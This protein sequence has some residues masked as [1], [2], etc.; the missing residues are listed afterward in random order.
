[1][2][3]QR[4][5]TSENP[6][7]KDVPSVK[8]QVMEIPDEWC[9]Y[10]WLTRATEIA[11]KDFRSGRADAASA[12]AAASLPTRHGRFAPLLF[13]RHLLAAEASVP[14]VPV[15]HLMATCEGLLS[16][17][18]AGTPPR[19]HKMGAA[20]AFQ[21]LYCALIDYLSREAE[22]IET[23]VLAYS[24]IRSCLAFRNPDAAVLSQVFHWLAHA[25]VYA[26]HPGQ[27]VAFDT[28]KADASRFMEFFGAAAPPEAFL[29]HAVDNL[30][31]QVEGV[32]GPDPLY[33]AVK[34]WRQTR[35]TNSM[36]PFIGPWSWAEL[37]PVLDVLYPEGISDCYTS[38]RARTIQY[39]E[40]AVTAAPAGV[41][42]VNEALQEASRQ[43]GFVDPSGV[44]LLVTQAQLSPETASPDTYAWNSTRWP[45]LGHDG[46]LL[47]VRFVGGTTI[48]KTSVLLRYSTGSLLLDFGLA[49]PSLDEW[50]WFDELDSVEAV[51]LSHAHMDHIGGFLPLYGTL[52]RPLPW[53]ALEGNERIIDTVLADAC[54]LSREET[55]IHQFSPR[56]VDHVMCN[57]NTARA[58][59]AVEVLPGVRATAFP[60][61]HVFGACSWLVE[62]DDCRVFFTGDFTH[63]R[64]LACMGLQWPDE[65]VL[66]EVDILITEGT[67]ADSNLVLDDAM[68]CQV[69]LVELT[70]S[71][72]EVAPCVLVPVMSLG[73]AQEVIRSLDG[74]GLRSGLFGMA[75]QI[76]KQ[77][78]LPMGPD[79]FMIEH[80]GSNWGDYVNGLDVLVAS[81]GSLSGGPSRVLFEEF[82]RAMPS[83]PVILTGHQFAGTAGRLL[84][85]EG[86][87]AV[88]FSAHA[89]QSDFAD[90]LLLFPKAR[91]F[92][93]HFPG[94]YMRLQDRYDVTVPFGQYGF[95]WG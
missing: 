73:R 68:T 95:R 71:L 7:S 32:A 74:S 94:D 66:A 5:P 16:K 87:H 64:P 69:K 67:Y 47:S 2:Q 13:Y 72:L 38:L 41:L 54:K 24:Y 11:Y 56:L 26:T 88:R 59:Q 84:E 8:S 92:V 15:L 34:N 50:P 46:R 48:G 44:P 37:R 86:G 22:D 83:R 85:K 21:A 79:T 58:G 43:T 90:T 65:A 20:V 81:S 82:F 31:L 25:A 57:L 78:N 23:L 28:L 35:K 53:F 27:P 52:Q 62:S 17:I 39:A 60:S 80:A 30:Y 9:G 36:E 12:V 63:R 61:G 93:I 14:E 70:R 6:A 75:S 91:K 89:S 4:D 40:A 77:I 10:P 33:E 18:A 19:P 29:R 51:L 55:A 42:P 49:N 76:T 1:M 45:G 3:T